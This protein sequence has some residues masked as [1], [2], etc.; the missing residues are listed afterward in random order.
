MDS[1][2]WHDEGEVIRKRLPSLPLRILAIAF[3]GALTMAPECVL[4]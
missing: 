3:H 2:K 4:S 1:S